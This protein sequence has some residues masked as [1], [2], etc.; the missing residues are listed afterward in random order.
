M[1][2]LVVPL[3][4]LGGCER[5]GNGVSESAGS[6]AVAEILGGAADEGFLRADT[7]RQFTFPEDHGPHPGFRNEW[8]YFTG[9]LEGPDGAPV[10]YQLTLFR[11]ELAPPGGTETE[12][13][14]ASAW[15]TRTAWMGHLAVTDG[16][17]GL[18]EAA[19]RFGREALDLAGART[20]PLRVWLEDWEVTGTE[21][22]FRLR[23]RTGELALDLG[24]DLEL[25]AESP[26]VLQGEDGL[27]PKGPEPGNASYYY[28]I[29]RLATG[30]SIAIG[31]R[32]V[33]VV[34]TSWLDREWSTSALSEGVVGWDWFALRLSDGWS[35]MVYD[36]RRADGSVTEF[37]HAVLM[38]PSGAKRPLSRSD[39]ELRVLDR[40][41]SPVDGALYPSGWRISV[42]SLELEL[43]VDPLV[44]DQEM[45]LAFRYW[46]GAVRVEGERDGRP[47]SGQGFVE[48]T[49]YA[50]VAPGGD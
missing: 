37:S 5:D 3:G 35:M 49:G 6:L 18:H 12:S 10:G 30:G 43:R 48:L 45:D 25:R 46:E 23:A 7:I 2:M 41:E 16:R 20:D 34:G 32:E 40:W 17:R 38:D 36:L 19:E 31:G 21:D 14:E 13:P 24:V 44:R 39:L 50:G 33:D 11:A 9:N 15:R 28:S 8:W 26:P 29:P 1:L 4:L 47:V 27:S 22:G 42:P